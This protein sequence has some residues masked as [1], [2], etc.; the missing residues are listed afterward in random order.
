MI[1]SFTALTNV[2][3]LQ[4]SVMCLVVYSYRSDNVGATERYKGRVN[5]F[6]VVGHIGVK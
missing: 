1:P 6:R 3:Y 2:T 5:V 4:P